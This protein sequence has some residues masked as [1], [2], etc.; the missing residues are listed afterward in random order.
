[1]GIF[2]WI[3][4]RREKC[5]ICG[6]QVL[7]SDETYNFTVNSVMRMQHDSSWNP[8]DDKEFAELSCRKAGLICKNCGIVVCQRCQIGRGGKCPKCG[9]I[10]DKPSMFG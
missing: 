3:F 5:A 9:V 4:K 1:M 7:S 10:G 2:D 6:K 8:L